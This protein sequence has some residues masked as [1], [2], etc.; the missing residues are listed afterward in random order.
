MRTVVRTLHRCGYEAFIV[1]GAARDFVL[2]RRPKDWDVATEATPETVERLFPKTIP[3]GKAFGT[4]TVLH[5]DMQIQVTTYRAERAY[6]DRRRP[7]EVRFVRDLV[8]DLSRRDFTMNAMAFDLRTRRL[9]DPFGGVEDLRR[10]R[11]RTVGKASKRFGEDILRAIRAG[12]F[13]AEH[14]LKP[15]AEVTKAA[16]AIAPHVRKLSKERIRDELSKLLLAPRPSVGLRW[17]DRTGILSVVF[18]GLEKGKGIRQGGWHSYD[19]FNHTLRAVDAAPP[20]LVLRLA[21]L[22]HDVAKPA[23]R[24]RDSRGYHFY[25]HEHLGARTAEKALIGLRYPRSLAQDVSTLVEH[26]LFEAEAISKSDPAIRRLMRR[27]GPERIERLLALRKADVLGCGPRSRVSPALQA[28]GRRVLA[29]RR[30]QEALSIRDLAVD[31]HDVMRLKKLSPGPQVGRILRQL[32]EEVIKKPI[33]N[34]FK[35]LTSI[36]QKL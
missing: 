36:I 33:L 23:T 27:V 29:I 22:F 32:M 4:I 28:I 6:R 26:H 20:D 11:L 16:R 5:P 2:K 8:A 25:R 24:S 19:V 21:L 31:G 7:G 3:T 35:D 15:S 10:R 1:G 9:V 18:P 17:L 14:D 12:R 13:I 34:N 30:A